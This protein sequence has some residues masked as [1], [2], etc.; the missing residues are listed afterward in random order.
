MCMFFMSATRHAMR[1][2]FSHAHLINLAFMSLERT[3]GSDVANSES[4]PFRVNDV[5]SIIIRNITY[6]AMLS[7]SRHNAPNARSYRH[8]AAVHCWHVTG[9]FKGETLTGYFC[10]FVIT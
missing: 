8:T 7:F 10:V 4:T 9:R 1:F 5:S 2:V 3:P 6:L